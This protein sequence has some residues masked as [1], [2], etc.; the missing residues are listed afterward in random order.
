MLLPVMRFVKPYWSF[1][2]LAFLGALGETVAD[3]LQPWPLKL[4]FDQIFN[5]RPLPAVISAFV[6]TTFGQ[7]ARDLLYFVLLAVIG[8]AALN[9]GSSYIQDFF[10][11]RI[12][13]RVIHDLR[14]QLYW[15]IQRLSLKYH[16]ERRM[17]DLLSTLTGDME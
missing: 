15:H 17:G 14:L 3:L 6:T 16:D 4:L 2:A 8:I 1:L 5:D 11:P 9:A 13:H 7:Q 12:S 10:M